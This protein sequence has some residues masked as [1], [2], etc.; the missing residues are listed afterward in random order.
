MSICCW[1][2]LPCVFA[3]VFIGD[4]NRSSLGFHGAFENNLGNFLSLS[5]ASLSVDIFEHI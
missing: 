3:F 5:T 2:K 1:E 4:S